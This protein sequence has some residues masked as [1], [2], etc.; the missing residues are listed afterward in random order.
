MIKLSKIYKWPL[1][2]STVLVAVS[3]L[4]LFVYGVKLGIDFSGGSLVEVNIESGQTATEV[5]NAL[6]QSGFAAQVQITGEGSYLIKTGELNQEGE[7]ETFLAA[8]A[9]NFGTYEELR[10]DSIGP[11]VGAELKRRATWQTAAVLIGILLYVAYAFRNVNQQK[12]VSVSS[13]RFSWASIFALAHDI[14]IL[15][16]V[17]AIIGAYKQVDID[18]LFV[19]AVLTTL[20]F[21]VND[22][23]VV[24]DRLRE[25]V[26][27]FRTDEFTENVDRSVS[28]TLARSLN[29]SGTL[30]FVLLAL[31]LFGGQ[32]TFYFAIALIVGVAVGTYSSIFI[33]SALLLAWNKS[34]N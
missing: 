33:A 23:I 22:T 8:V 28:Q 2:I 15:L 9:E 4:L 31:A 18:T 7:H 14:I 12:N 5:S 16:G 20:G 3:L 34:K 25:N 13:W 24:F 30:L 11:V 32:T 17:F 10:F 21:S 27:R 6:Q 19:T 26:H 29:T 1:I